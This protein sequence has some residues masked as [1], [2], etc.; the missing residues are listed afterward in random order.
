MLKQ[1]NGFDRLLEN[2]DKDDFHK[3]DVKTVVKPIPA[4]IGARWRMSIAG[5][6]ND[7]ARPEAVQDIFVFLK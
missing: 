1:A 6:F 4:A 5:K 2:E 7:L 3:L